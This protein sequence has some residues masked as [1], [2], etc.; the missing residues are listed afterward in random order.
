MAG[1][2]QAASLVTQPGPTARAVR[3]EHSGE[4]LRL[5]RLWQRKQGLSWIFAAVDASDL[6]DD[7]IDRLDCAR[8]DARVVLPRAIEPVHLVA[9]LT[10]ASAKAA[11]AHLVLPAGW[12][13]DAPWWQLLNTFRERLADAFPKPLIWWLPDDCITLAARNAPDFWNW[14]DTVLNFSVQP[15]A[16]PASLPSARFEFDGRSEKE[17]VQ[18]RLKDIE[19]YL[20]RHG[21]T[22]AAAAHLL[23]EAASAN[24]R[25]G[26]WDA[27]MRCA[28]QAHGSFIDLGND[29]LAAQAKG[30]I[31]DILQARGKLDEALA[32]RQSDQL[33]VYEQQGDIRE[34]A[35]TKGK[36]ADIL[37]ARGKLDEA[38]AIRQNDELPVYEQLGDIREVA[39]T[40][41]KIADILKA[42]G[43]LDEALAIRQNDQLPVYEQLGD[44]RSVAITK[45]KIAD[46]LKLRDKLE[47]A[48]AMLQNDVFPVFSELG[49]IHSAAVTKAKIAD[50]LQARGK[51]DEALAML[52]NDVF[53]VFSELGDIRSA[54]VTKGNI[55]NILQARGKLDEALAIWRDYALP[56]FES[57]GYVPEADFAHARIEAL[58]AAK[59]QRKRAT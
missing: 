19:D 59:R 23:L 14:R 29:R 48:L 1:A 52:Q 32:I 17:A 54:A 40:K 8:T 13:P 38:L 11:R 34:A 5:A 16:V 55:A 27:S 26:L 43:K 51:L 47:E 12:Q 6:R 31:A 41:G 15:Q 10:D 37:Q 35:I 28:R 42:R 58:E 4:Y 25:L 21:H 57:A 22:G 50:I 18:R 44:I 9:L 7:L 24:Q 33:P 30:Q 36:I 2:A 3:S 39:V 49:D 20:A 53:P 56:V 46:I 45:G